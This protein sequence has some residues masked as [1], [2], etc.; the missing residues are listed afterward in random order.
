MKVEDSLLLCP[1]A[2][3]EGEHPLT[4]DSRPGDGGA[5]VLHQEAA[6]LTKGGLLI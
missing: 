5:H 1:N 6:S 4:E 2:H 3:E